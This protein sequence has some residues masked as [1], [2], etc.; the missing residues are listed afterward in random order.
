MFASAHDVDHPKVGSGLSM[1]LLN[2]RCSSS[3]M[4][5]YKPSRMGG[6][7]DLRLVNNLCGI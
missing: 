6:D 2:Q 4:L 7:R 3:R 1:N 5:S